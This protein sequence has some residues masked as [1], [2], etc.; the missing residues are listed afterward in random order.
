MA[1][2][3]EVAD[4]LDGLDE[5]WYV[6]NHFLNRLPVEERLRFRR[7]LIR[8]LRHPEVADIP[9]V[10]DRFFA[11]LDGPR[12]RPSFDAPLCLCGYAADKHDLLTGEYAESGCE[13]FTE[14]PS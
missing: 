1:N 13:G 9:S 7:T 2:A 6:I 11:A 10:R 5:V 12:K 8:R 4:S 14:V 3:K